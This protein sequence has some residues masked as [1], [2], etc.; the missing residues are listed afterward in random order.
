MATQQRTEEEIQEVLKQLREH[1]KQQRQN[2]TG[3]KRELGNFICVL[4]PEYFKTPRLSK[5]ENS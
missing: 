2:P 3:P 4:R 5:K 1:V